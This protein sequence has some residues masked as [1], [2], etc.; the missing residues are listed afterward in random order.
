ML[1]AEQIDVFISQAKQ[2]NKVLVAGYGSLLSQYSRKTFS[3]I[4]AV[5]LSALVQGWQRAWITRSIDENQTYAGATPSAKHSVSVQ[6]IALQFDSSFE[7]REQD[8]KFTPVQA[9]DIVLNDQ[10]KSH[11]G[12]DKLLQTTPIY[13]CETL[14]IE[15]SNV[16]FP[17]HFSYVNTCLQGCFENAGMQGVESFFHYTTSWNSTFFKD[18]SKQTRYPR[19]TPVDKTPWQLSEL[20]TQYGANIIKE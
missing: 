10:L 17:V 15:P 12:I 14:K 13:I 4:E 11:S 1:T 6:L 18:D 8:Y 19:A 5:G 16:P 20:L 3:K 2:P 9:S 7:K